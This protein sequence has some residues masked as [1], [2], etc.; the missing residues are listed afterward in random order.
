MRSS[1][2]SVTYG[3]TPRRYLLQFGVL[4]SAIPFAARIDHPGALSSITIRRP[5]LR[6][7]V[8]ALVIVSSSCVV[9]SSVTRNHR[10]R[11]PQAF[12]PMALRVY[13]PRIDAMRNYSCA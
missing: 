7:S 2:L 10:A 6:P 3:A 11:R 5:M 4:I 13:Q 1:A 12:R 9:V 8:C